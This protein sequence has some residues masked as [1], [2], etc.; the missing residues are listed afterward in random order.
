MAATD[1][2]RRAAADALPAVEMTP[3]AHALA[4]LMS[5]F[6]EECWC[7]SWLTDTEFDVWDLIAG[8]RSSWGMGSTDW[9]SDL[10]AID[11]LSKAAGVWIVYRI[12]DHGETA[13]D[14]NAWADLDR[15]LPAPAGEQTP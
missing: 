10:A 3:L 9:D 15:L 2:P 7:A 4:T 5:E 13:V 12:N 14:R 6:S 11:E 1:D 8:R